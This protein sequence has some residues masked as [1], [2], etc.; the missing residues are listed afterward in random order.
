MGGP[1]LKVTYCVQKN[2]F[3]PCYKN[4][5]PVYII[6]HN[7]H[8]YVFETSGKNDDGIYQ[9]IISTFKFIDSNPAPVVETGKI[10]GKVLL[11]PTCPV[12][13]IPPD[14]NCAP[15]PYQTTVKVIDYS[16][17]A[18]VKETESDAGGNFQTVLPPGKYDVYA[19]GGSV[20]PRCSPQTVEVN[21]GKVAEITLYCDTGI[22]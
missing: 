9:Q 12:E 1:A 11:G 5:N 10:I 6:L 17:S 22:R 7:A 20:Y 15:K 4:L 14:P 8:F 2:D 19:G 21:T 13:R 16:S 18:L 3:E